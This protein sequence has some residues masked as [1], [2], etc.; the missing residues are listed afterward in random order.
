MDLKTKEELMEIICPSKTLRTYWQSINFELS[1]LQMATI[2]VHSVNYFPYSMQS[3]I[4]ENMILITEDQ[5][6]KTVLSNFLAKAEETFAAFKTSESNCVFEVMS[7]DASLTEEGHASEDDSEGLAFDYDTA[8]LIKE[9]SE[10]RVTSIIKRR[11]FANS[12]YDEE[13]N[14][15]LG[16]IDYDKNGD[17]S[18]IFSKTVGEYYD[19]AIPNKYISM[20][21]PFHRG[22]VVRNVRNGEWGVVESEPLPGKDFYDFEK[23][24]PAAFKC[25]YEPL[26]VVEHIAKDGTFYHEHYDPTVLETVPKEDSNKYELFECA[27][28]LMQGKR[29]LCYMDYLKEN[30]KANLIGAKNKI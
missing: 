5:E 19:D 9:K 10:N 6:S 20:P 30:Y 8:L 12:Q 14:S 24:I 4:I 3:K 26:I 21:H 11:V 15:I 2:L 18:N 1:L 28:L 17:I 13:E 29:S 23:Q 25:E 27:G 16:R 22:D 7:N